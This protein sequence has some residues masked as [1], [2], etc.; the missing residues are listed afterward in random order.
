MN[1]HRVKTGGIVETVKCTPLLG[2]INV[3]YAKLKKKTHYNGSLA[4]YKLL[5]LIGFSYT[6]Y[7]CSK[8]SKSFPEISI[9]HRSW[10]GH[11]ITGCNYKI[12]FVWK[13]TL[14][15]KNWFKQNSEIH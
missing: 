1:K 15:S 12:S 14:V 6:V 2:L 11:Q 9:E 8:L 7:F 4:M 10:C 13:G 5:V 3:K